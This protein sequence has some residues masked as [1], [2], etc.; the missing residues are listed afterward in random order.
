MYYISYAIS[1]ITAVH[2]E[3]FIEKKS[4][5]TH[6]QRKPCAKKALLTQDVIGLVKDHR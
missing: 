1:W 4:S 2:A 3:I 6:V 5:Y